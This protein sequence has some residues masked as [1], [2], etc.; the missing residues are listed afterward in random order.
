MRIGQGVEW[1]LHCCLTLAWAGG[2]EPLPTARLAARFDLPAAYLN[3]CLQA[4]AQAGILTSTAGSRGG[5]RLARPPAD[6]TL[7]DVVAAIEGEAPAFRC[8]EIRQRAGADADE[9]RQPCSVAQA[10]HIAE[11][12]WREALSRQT[13]ADV[14]AASPPHA[15]ARARRWFELN[16][17]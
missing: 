10:M 8:T 12:A 11:T 1:G 16:R 9:C 14:M 6:I 4:L 3:K 7:W 5:F 15:P 13:L 2:S 17:R